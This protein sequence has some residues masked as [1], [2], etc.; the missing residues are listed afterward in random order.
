MMDI[1]AEVRTALNRMAGE[2][3][4]PPGAYELNRPRPS[5]QWLPALLAAA[6]VI[7][8]GMFASGIGIDIQ[9]QESGAVDRNIAATARSSDAPG[10]RVT[11]VT[12]EGLVRGAERL[13]G[14][15]LEPGFA[16]LEVDSAN[17]RLVLF[18]VGALTDNAR[19]LIDSLDVEVSVRPAPY[20]AERLSAASNRLL[21]DLESTNA[22]EL[23]SYVEFADDLDGLRVLASQY[24]FEKSD[25]PELEQRWSQA[26]GL[27]VEVMLGDTSRM[28]MQGLRR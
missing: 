10:S 11:G 3:H 13:A 4:V 17:D 14:V 27:P 20:S 8:I 9:S 22:R 18:W 6:A 15:E 2:V 16:K 26:A 7:T 5:K 12:D 28:P 19:T 21:M 1:E 24:H 23:V 25:V